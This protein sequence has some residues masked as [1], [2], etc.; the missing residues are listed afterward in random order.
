MLSNNQKEK[1]R[2]DKYAFLLV[3]LYKEISL[4]PEIISPPRFRIKG[5][6]PEPDEQRRTKEDGNS[7][8]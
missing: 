3:L 8:V 4:Q 5:R 1:K 2:K 7:C 6:L